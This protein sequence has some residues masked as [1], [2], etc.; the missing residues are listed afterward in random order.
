MTKFLISTFILIFILSCNNSNSEK[1]LIENPNTIEI[2]STIIPLSLRNYGQ[3]PSVDDLAN[4][5]KKLVTQNRFWY[6]IEKDF[7]EDGRKD[8]IYIVKKFDDLNN[9]YYFNL[10]YFK[11]K[12]LDF[13]AAVEIAYLPKLGILE[14]DGSNIKVNYG[15]DNSIEYEFRDNKWKYLKTQNNATHDKSSRITNDLNESKSNNQNNYDYEMRSDGKV[16]ETNPCS[17]C[18]GKGVLRGR[19]IISGEIEYNTCQMC[20]GQGVRSY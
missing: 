4:N 15:N 10:L 12:R 3:I 7:D 2:D 9:Q 6:L 18:K 5:T 20:E 11:K 17:M 1:N 8:R 19:N 13:D 14:L 16:Y